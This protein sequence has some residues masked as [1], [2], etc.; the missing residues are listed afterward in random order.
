MKF[1]D[2]QTSV[3]NGN[4]LRVEI[5]GASHADEIGV[6]VDGFPKAKVDLDK[7]QSFMDRRRAK[8]TAYSTKRFEGDKVIVESGVA[9]G[10]LDDKFRAVIKNSQQK[11]ADY[12][13]VV[14]TPRPAHADFVA[15][16]KYGDG[17]DYRGGGK[18]SGRMT[19]PMCIAG[20]IL[21]QILQEKGIEINAYIS[22]IGNVKG[23]SY[24]DIDIDQF[25]FCFEDENFQLLDE[26]VKEQMIDEI[27]SARRL[28][29]SVGGVIECVI[30][31]VPVG[32]GEYMFDSLE[33]VISHLV[34]AVPAVKGIE[35]GTGFN[36]SKMRGSQA[37]DSFFYSDGEVKTRTNNN[38]GIN[39]GMANGMPITF[40]V[41]I[42]PTPSILIEQDTVNLTEKT[43]TKLKIAGRH[44]ACITPRAVAVI[45]AVSAIAIFDSLGV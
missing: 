22:Q 15:W 28:G 20:G 36:I 7:L 10:V 37:N 27:E 40:R 11:S 2:R 4:K 12:Q 17:F 14:K 26:S 41:A 25:K 18:F 21:K 3:F 23:K 42:K 31:G 45:E 16:A 5:F 44:D 8:N 38:G 33:S 6:I 19:A 24:N 43:N 39:G 1:N 13:N 35:F 9:N 34:F 29:D 32:T 30:T